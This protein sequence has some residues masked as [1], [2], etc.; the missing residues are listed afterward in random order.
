[1]AAELI[2]QQTGFAL[3]GKEYIMDAMQEVID[4]DNDASDELRPLGQA[5][6]EII[7]EELPGTFAEALTMIGELG[8]QE[9]AL[10]TNPEQ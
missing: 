4:M 5:M 6:T 9:I 7:G 10:A 3:S 1:L 2:K 8:F